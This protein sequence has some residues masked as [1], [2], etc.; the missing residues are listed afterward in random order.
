VHVGF[1]R[2]VS[3]QQQTTGVMGPGSGAGTTW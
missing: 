1:F 2:S 3:L